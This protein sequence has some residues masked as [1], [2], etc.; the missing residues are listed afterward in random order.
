M[1]GKYLV[2]IGALAFAHLTAANSWAEPTAEFVEDRIGQGP[3]KFEFHGYARLPVLLADGPTGERGPD[4]VDDNYGQSGFAYLRANE[5]EWV[6]MTLSAVNG[7]TRVVAGILANQLSDWSDRQGANSTPAFAF[8]E[9]Q[10]EITTN[11][12]LKT[13]FGMFWRRLGYHEQ[14]DTY[15][16]GRTH[17]AGAMATFSAHELVEAEFGFGTHARNA[18]EAFGFGPTYWTRIGAKWRVAASMA[19]ISRP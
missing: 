17:L 16:I 8:V 5:T 18:R 3:W 11:Y 12:R 10:Q 4:L 6:E 7:P 13:R 1:F 9:H 14:Y 19:T 15:L 2:L